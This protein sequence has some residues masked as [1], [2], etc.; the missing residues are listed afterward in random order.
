MRRGKVRGR[1]TSG[2]TIN[3]EPASRLQDPPLLFVPTCRSRPIGRTQACQG[4]NTPTGS[5]WRSGRPCRTSTPNRRPPKAAML[6][7][8]PCVNEGRPPLQ[9]TDRQ[10][11]RGACPRTVEVRAVHDLLGY[12]RTRRRPMVV[13]GDPP[14]RG[15]GGCFFFAVEVP[16]GRR[17][18]S[19]IHDG[20]WRGLCLRPGTCRLPASSRSREPQG[21]GC[22][23]EKCNKSSQWVL[24]PAGTPGG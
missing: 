20:D 10:L 21:R 16:A 4:P 19:Y 18:P 17:I 24:E 22:H 23:E 8:L 11:C 5:R 6:P 15:K 14:G 9:T 12:G 2:F 13:T 7:A 3:K 1:R